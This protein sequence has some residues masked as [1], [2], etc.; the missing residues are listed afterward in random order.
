MLLHLLD[1]YD[2]D[3]TVREYELAFA[4]RH[5][6]MLKYAFE[7]ATDDGWFERRHATEE[8]D[9]RGRTLVREES[10]VRRNHGHPDAGFC[11]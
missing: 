7:T 2:L 1:H 11:E 3:W 10:P 5:P 4:S 8:E 6:D 9:N